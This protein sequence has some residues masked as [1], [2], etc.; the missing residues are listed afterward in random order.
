MNKSSSSTGKERK[1]VA[2]RRS[3]VARKGKISR[4]DSKPGAVV[5]RDDGYW[6]WFLSKR[7][8][9]YVIT[10]KYLFFSSDRSILVKVALNEIQNFGFHHAKINKEPIV[11]G[12][13][14]V[15]CL[16]Y[17]DDSRKFELHDRHVGTTD[18]KYRYWKSDAATLNG[19]YSEEFLDGLTK[20]ERRHFGPRKMRLIPVK[21][22]DEEVLKG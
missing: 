22:G 13:D 9:D 6:E 3:V 18:L 8:L 4:P 15:L 20:E 14:L 5:V 11:K 1:K 7:P 21:N 19:E 16:Y 12:R 2:K 17:K 10:G